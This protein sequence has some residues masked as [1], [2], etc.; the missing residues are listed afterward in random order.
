VDP[1][2]R[3]RQE[4]KL[5]QNREISQGSKQVQKGAGQRIRGQGRQAGSEQA[6]QE[7]ILIKLENL[8]LKHKT[9]WQRTSG[10]E[11]AK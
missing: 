3:L 7:Y 8:A 6:G 1:K 2:V 9:I 11:G 10:S 5:G 4:Y